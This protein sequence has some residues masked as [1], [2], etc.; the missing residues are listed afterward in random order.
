MLRGTNCRNYID[1]YYIYVLLLNYIAGASRS[2]FSGSALEDCF[3]G[4]K[5]GHITAQSPGLDTLLMEMKSLKKFK[6]SMA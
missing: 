2:Y 5:I 3:R 6:F 4:T 1:V